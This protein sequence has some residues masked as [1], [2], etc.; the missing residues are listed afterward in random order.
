MGREP[1]PMFALRDKVAVVTGGGGD[2][3]AAIGRR[4]ARAGARVVLVDRDANAAERAAAAIQEEG[5]DA[6]FEECDVT[7]SAHADEVLRCTTSRWGTPEIL[8]N[9][10]A[11]R[12]FR[13]FVELDE[14]L[15]ERHLRVNMLAPM[16]WTQLVAQRLIDERRPG[17]V[18]NITSVVSLRGFARNAAY[19]SSKAALLGLSRCAAVD[20]APYEIRVNCVAPGPTRTRLT[21]EPLDDEAVARQLEARIPLARRHAG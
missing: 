7:D 20:L 14:V 15:V 6:A 16:R 17:S 9:G 11:V 5:L 13:E 21:A 8:V 4:L 18:V 12:T 2:I 1:R 10:A 3:C 19:A